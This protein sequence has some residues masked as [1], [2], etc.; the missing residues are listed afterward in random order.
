[1]APGC[2]AGVHD[3]ARPDQARWRADTQLKLA[4]ALVQ[5][6]GCESTAEEALQEAQ[7]LGDMTPYAHK[8]PERR[9]NE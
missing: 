6:E 1:M 8:P 7:Q 9:A 5:V 2:T 3:G 4:T